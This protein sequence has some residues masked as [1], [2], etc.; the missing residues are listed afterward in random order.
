[1]EQSRASVVIRS[2]FAVPVVV[3]TV[4]VGSSSHAAACARPN[5]SSAEL[6][7]I[8]TSGINQRVL[9][10]AITK[11]TNYYRCKRGMGPLANDNRLVSAA[12]THSRNMA[13]LKKL[14]HV[15]PISGSKTLKQRFVR[16]DV[17]V[18][19]VRAENIGTE[20]R[21]KFGTGVFIINDRQNC[22]FTYRASRKPIPQHSYASLAHSVVKRW[23]ESKS[24]RKNILNRH[25]KRVGSAAQFTSAGI[26]PCGTYYVTQDLAG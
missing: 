21:L 19:K 22:R 24:H 2:I 26:A 18:K 5:F 13:R 10:R 3:A 20:Y 14:S 8:P 25:V 15:L 11:E 1:M 6:K 4:L 23:W 12:Q 16:A 9:S 17:V 7:A